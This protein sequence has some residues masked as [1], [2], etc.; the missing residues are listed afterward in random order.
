MF[1]LADL[2]ALIV[3]AIGGAK[4]SLAFQ[5]GRNPNPGGHIMLGGIFLQLSKGSTTLFPLKQN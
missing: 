3:Q 5:A 2:V 1:I 4:A